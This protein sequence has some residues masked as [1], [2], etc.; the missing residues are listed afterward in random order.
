MNVH[1]TLFDRAACACALAEGEKGVLVVGRG[2]RWAGRCGPS[3]ELDC[4]RETGLAFVSLCC[5]PKE[6]VEENR[7]ILFR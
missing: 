2:P 1:A 5:K 6:M 3:R 7:Y 4:L